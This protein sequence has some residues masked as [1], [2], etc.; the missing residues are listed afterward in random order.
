MRYSIVWEY[1]DVAM[2]TLQEFR[3]R[4]P[5]IVQRLNGLAKENEF[6]GMA[7]TEGSMETIAD[8][9]A[10]QKALPSATAETVPSLGYAL[11]PQEV[12]VR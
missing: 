5:T 6:D 11:A 3:Q 12:I 9:V 4:F 2:R 1:S 10:W 7:L 8:L